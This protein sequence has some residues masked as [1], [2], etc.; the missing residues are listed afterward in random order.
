MEEISKIIA[1]LKNELA[2]IKDAEKAQS[3]CMNIKS[4]DSLK[5]TKIEHLFK[6]KALA[7]ELGNLAETVID[8]ED[9]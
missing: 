1:K 5:K 2:I 7:R 3:K 8:V 4:Y 6:I 9:L